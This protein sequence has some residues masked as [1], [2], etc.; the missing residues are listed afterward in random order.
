MN[1]RDLLEAKYTAPSGKEFTFFWEKLSR[2]TELKTGVFLFPDK[3]GAHV[4]HQGGGA[5]SYP[6]T[7][8]FNGEG[9]VQTANDFEAALQEKDIA[10]LQHPVYG[11]KKV[12]PTGSISRDNDL[13]NNINESHVTVTFTETIADAPVKLE[14]VSMDE[15]TAG[16]DDFMEAAAVDFAEGLTIENINDKLFI[17]SALDTQTN[18]LNDTLSALAQDKP[19]FITATEELKTSIKTIFDNEEK[20]KTNY[21]NTARLAL[22]TMKIP[23][24]AAVG[25][26]EK[27][28]GYTALVTQIQSQFRNDPFGINSIK[29][30]FASTRL[31]LFG[32]VASIA[33]G[34]VL[35]ISQNSANNKRETTANSGGGSGLKNDNSGAVVSREEAVS[36]AVQL[37]NLLG[38]IQNYEDGKITNND[39]INNTITQVNEKLNAIKENKTIYKYVSAEYEALKNT[40]KEYGEAKIDGDNFKKTLAIQINDIVNKLKGLNT[41]DTGIKSIISQLEN[42]LNN[43]QENENTENAEKQSSNFVDFSATT[44]FLLNK[45][46][47]NSINMIFNIALALPMK[48]IIKLT[49]DRNI[50]ELCAEIYQSVDNSF[51]DKLIIENNLN[52]DDMEIIPMG[53]E[54]FYYV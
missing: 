26:L 15:L 38:T 39:N 52:I 23:S 1:D 37:N 27:M 14:A 8:I 4:Q 50:I 3:D 31:V 5:V 32:A 46:V 20:L 41:A 21:L 34:S 13:I 12:I 10:E 6:M 47:C 19:D 48:K 53:R 40:I 29:N 44:Y 24:R 28:R 51:I 18:I 54:V 2:T 43:I 35:A 17:Q 9:H 30:A 49:Y 42:I 45:T 7:C 33:V 22:N 11:I 16:F 36:V 25:V